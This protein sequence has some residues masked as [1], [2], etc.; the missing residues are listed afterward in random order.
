[1][2]S[3]FTLIVLGAA[4]L[5][6]AREVEFALVKAPQDPEFRSGV[7][8]RVL[9]KFPPNTPVIDSK[10]LAQPDELK[11]YKRIFIYD[12]PRIFTIE[13]LEGIEKYV[14]EGGLLVTCS[15]MSDIDIDHDGKGDFSLLTQFKK[16]KPG[17]PRP[18]DY[19]PTGILAH[20]SAQIQSVTAKLDCPLTENFAVNTPQ[21]MNFSFRSVKL[22]SGIVIMTAQAVLKNKE[23]LKQMPLISV[24]NRNK[25]S[26]IFMPFEKNFITNSLSSQTLDWLTD[27]E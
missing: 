2:K 24:C 23:V 5:L 6:S 22:K 12:V 25:G 1:M 9:A 10:I 15:I 13:Q 16:R 17:H 26:F 11:K 18:K 8:Q 14:S 21:A 4:A 19:P 7:F 3:F 27:Q 20:S